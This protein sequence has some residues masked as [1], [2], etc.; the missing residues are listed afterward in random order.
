MTSNHVACD[1]MD[2]L[3]L[4]KLIAKEQVVYYVKIYENTTLLRDWFYSDDSYLKRTKR[5]LDS[6]G[7]NSCTVN[8]LLISRTLGEL[9]FYSLEIIFIH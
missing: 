2:V 3:T 1:T 6:I 8:P 7:C 9:D 5:L 4:D